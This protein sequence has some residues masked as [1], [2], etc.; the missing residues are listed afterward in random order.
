MVRTFSLLVE[1]DPHQSFIL[2]LNREIRSFSDPTFCFCC[3]SAVG[4][5]PPQNNAPR[6]DA[7]G[8]PRFDGGWNDKKSAPRADGRGPGGDASHVVEPRWDDRSGPLSDT[9]SDKFRGY[10]NTEPSE[11]KSAYASSSY[12]AQGSSAYASS[13]APPPQWR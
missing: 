7:R 9:S 8:P 11:A 10:V 3:F 13:S 2:L 5:P 1:F 6:Y 12:A 4:P